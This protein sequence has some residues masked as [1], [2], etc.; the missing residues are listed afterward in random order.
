M[1]LKSN[2][3]FKEKPTCSFKYDMMNLVNF[4]SGL[5]LLGSFC[6]KYI[7]FELKYRGV[8]FHNTEQ[9]FEIRINHDLALS[10]MAWVI[11]WNFIRTLKSL[12]KYT[13]MGYFLSK[14]YNVSAGKFQMNYVSWQWRIMQ[15]VKKKLTRGLKNDIRSF[16]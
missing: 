9:W 7:R 2:A 11:D 14:A 5:S 15:N 3:K 10:K 8:I 1:K 16:G 12:K 6:P 13:L 4:H